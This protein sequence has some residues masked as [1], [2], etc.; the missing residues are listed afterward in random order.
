VKLEA[1]VDGHPAR[2]TTDGTHLRY[3]RDD[4]SPI[5]CEFSVTTLDPG[6]YSVLIEGRSYTVIAA[7]GGEISVNGRRISVEI[8]DPR[9]RGARKSAGAGSGRQNIVAM[10]PGKVVRVVVA[11]NDIVEAGQGLIVVEA[12]KMQNE[13][14]SPRTGRVVELKTK[15]DATV[16]AGGVLMVIE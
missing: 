10:M 14:V 11:V 5:D 2:F 8:F 1:T 7:P 9:E 4:A 13:I 15:A 6:A 3:E 12:M 16:S